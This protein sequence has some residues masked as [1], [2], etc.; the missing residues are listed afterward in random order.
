METAKSPETHVDSP[1]LDAPSFSTF[2]AQPLRSFFFLRQAT[3]HRP[4]PLNHLSSIFVRLGRHHVCCPF[5]VRSEFVQLPSHCEILKLCF[6]KESDER[7]RIPTVFSLRWTA[8]YLCPH[9]VAFFPP[10][11]APNPL[12]PPVPFAVSTPS[13]HPLSSHPLKD[14]LGPS[15][16]V[17]T[18]VIRSSPSVP[19]RTWHIVRRIPSSKFS[20][21][22]QVPI[23]PRSVAK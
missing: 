22:F 18:P 1:F 6:L 5:L 11:C 9:L 8:T 23:T 19:A 17:P 13:I 12:S 2:A 21:I 14:H 4:S 20:A 3:P 15:L 7:D 10:L 16:S